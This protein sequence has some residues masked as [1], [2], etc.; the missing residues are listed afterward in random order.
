MT[1]QQLMAA[2]ALMKMYGMKSPF[3]EMLDFYTKSPEFQ[4]DVERR[5]RE[6]GAP[7]EMQIK[8][9]EAQ[10]A[11]I[12]ASNQNKLDIAK[13][14][15]GKGVV[16]LPDGSFKVIESAAEAFA[17]I[18]AAKP[19]GDLK[20]YA[21]YAA[22][23]KARGGIPKSYEVW[24][25][26]RRKAGATAINTA[27]GF[28]A[29][30]MK[31]RIAI[32]QKVAQEAADQALAGRRLMPVL[33]ELAYMADK[34][35]E[36]WAGPLSVPIGRTLAAIGVPVS[37]GMTNAETFGSLAQR[38]VPIVREPGATSQGEMALYLSAGPQLTGT[39]TGRKM[40]IA[41]NK[42]MVERS[43]QIAKVYRENLGSP[44][45]YEKLADLDR[46][47]FTDEQRAALR[48]AVQ[49]PSNEASPTAPLPSGVP[50]W[51]PAQ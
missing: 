42:A 40:I 18:E 22:Q 11:E 12:R 27:E 21:A 10:L 49:S 13:D 38:L 26:Q 35:P 50:Q 44:S 5:K 8:Q 37:A 4:G 2:D 30:Q 36:G 7:I 43:Q 1:P 29:A 48:G 17:A 28:D 47:L 6:A 45:L 31:A 16:Q 41:M 39:A 20:E 15:I 19:T 24:D 23:E 9:Y 51:R 32:D 14:L 46:P 33:D 3:G 25:L 34:T